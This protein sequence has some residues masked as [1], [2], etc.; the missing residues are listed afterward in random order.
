MNQF[1]CQFF[2]LFYFCVGGTIISTHKSRNVLGLKMKTGLFMK[3]TLLWA[4]NG[5]R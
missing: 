5:P 1:I 4:T 3:L 2:F